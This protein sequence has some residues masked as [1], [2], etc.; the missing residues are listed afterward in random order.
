MAPSGGEP[1]PASGE[2]PA[3][4]PGRRPTA[5]LTHGS[6]PAE[7][8]RMSGSMAPHSASG[9]MNAIYRP[10][11]GGLLTTLRLPAFQL[12]LALLGVRPYGYLGL[13]GGLVLADLVSAIL[14]VFWI[15]YLVRRHGEVRV[16][17]PS[18]PRT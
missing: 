6:V 16:S 4:P 2:A 1:T 7:L 11:D 18:G 5:E 12:P 15:G 9:A 8:L 14:T 13:L 17:A 3:A 10:L